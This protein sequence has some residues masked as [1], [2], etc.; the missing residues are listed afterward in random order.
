MRCLLSIILLAW[1]ALS[2]GQLTNGLTFYAPLDDA[3]GTSLIATYPASSN[4]VSGVV[5][6]PILESAGKVGTSFLFNSSGDDH[7]LT[8]EQSGITMEYSDFSMFMWIKVDS[9]YNQTDSSSMYIVGGETGSACLMLK[10]GSGLLTFVKRNVTEAPASDLVPTRGAWHFIGI[11]FNSTATTNNLI[12]YLDEEEDTVTCNI[13]FDVGA[14]SSVIGQA[15]TTSTSSTSFMGS[16]DEIGFWKRLLTADEVATLYNSGDGLTYPF[17]IPGTY[18]PPQFIPSTAQLGRS[19][20]TYGTQS[21]YMTYDVTPAIPDITFT[22]YN[23]WDFETEDLGF[24]SDAEARQD[25]DVRTL[26]SHSTGYIVDE[27]INNA[28]TQVLR[29]THAA[30]QLTYGYELFA[31]LNEDYDELYLSYNVKFSENFSSTRGGKIPGLG[32]F[33]GFTANVCPLPTQGFTVANLFKRAGFSTTYHYDQTKGYCAWSGDAEP[34]VYMTDTIWMNNGQWYNITQRVRINTFTGSTANA[35]GIN[36]IW[37]DG[38]MMYQETNVKYLGTQNDTLKID[39][40][41]MMHFYG[42]DNIADYAP[43]QTCYG[44]MDNFTIWTPV[45]DPTFGTQTA[46]DPD[47][48]LSTP[49]PITNK[50]VYY[51]ALVTTEGTLQNTMYGGQYASCTDEA[52]LIDAGAGNTVS[53]NITGGLLGGGDYLFFYD[54]NQSDSPLIDV[55]S[56]YTSNINGTR[57]S[58]GRY[59]FVRFSSDQDGATTGGFTGTVSFNP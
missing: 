10:I 2:F 55:R 51:D 42:G 53:Y 43:K 9:Y 56:G 30:N 29:V 40:L 21:K 33:P 23:S 15:H 5:G 18:D 38:R 1:S 16:I 36:E 31:D 28:S 11:R 47:V 7:I 19:R 8:Q 39:A 57:T 13:N 20:P 12:Y 48:I 27:I 24:Y 41:K 50:D 59:M 22:V 52:Y 25:F 34:V 17:Y 46:H 58:T 35:D 6:T 44:Y 37:I 4:Y 54:G 3:V 14:S 45:N 26:N 49:V 32:G